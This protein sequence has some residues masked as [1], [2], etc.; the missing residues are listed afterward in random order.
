MN[1]RLQL[2]LFFIITALSLPAQILFEENFEGGSVPTDWSIQTNATDGGWKVGTPASLSTN[3]FPIAA[4]GSTRIAATNDDACNCNKS[5]EYFVTPVIDLSTVSTAVLTFDAYYLGQ[6]YQGDTEDASVDISLDGGNTWTVLMPI[7]G[8]PA[9]VNHQVNLTD[10]VGQSVTIGFRYDDNGGWL[11]GFGLDNVVVEVPPALE[12][13]LVEVTSRIFGE[14][15][16]NLDIKGELLNAG[17]NA[18]TSVE[19][20]YTVNGGTPVVETLDNLNIAAFSSYDFQTSSPW[21]PASAG[22]F[23]IEVSVT[24]V[25]GGQDGNPDDNSGSYEPEI[26]AQ[27]TVPNKIAT[28][29]ET[30]PILT[31]MTG[32]SSALNRPTDLDFFPILGKDELWV[33]NQRTESQGGSTLTISD[34]TA[35]TPTN[36]NNLTDGN[37]WHFMSLPSAIAFSSDNF[38]FANSPGVQDA[39][40]QGGTFTGPSLWSSDLAIYAQP[41]GGNG[42]HLDMLHGS[43][44]SRGIA[45]EVD[46][47]F[48]VYDDYNNDI[49]RY[50]FVEDHGPGNDDHSDAIVRRFQ[51]IGI[52][53][54][55]DIPN[56]MLVDKAT[57]WLYFVDNGNDRVIRLDINSGTSSNPLSEINEP[58]AE[59]SQIMGFNFEVIIDS[60]LDQPCGLEIFE[61]YLM[62]GDYATGDILVYDM[63]NDFAPM[64]VIPT[65][66]PGLTGIKVGPDGNIWYT[67][68]LQNTLSSVQPGDP[69]SV[70]E[71]KAKLD[72]KVSPNPT[73]G[74]VNVNLEAVQNLEATTI[75]VFNAVGQQTLQINATDNNQELDLSHMPNGV[76]WIKVEGERVSGTQRVVLNR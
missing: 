24:M 72:F 19:L 4:N 12:I 73:N 45:H 15:G 20:S 70:S 5:N 23:D 7:E 49:V 67:N 16:D 48:W 17:A 34:A 55:G 58:L 1:K 3:A 42:S 69:V 32:A 46:N 39:N 21:V 18:I 27:V 14:V 56:H 10:Y 6:T 65:L 64:G 57:G 30:T 11:Y 59:H 8:E 75:Q 61:N 52:N 33:I 76:Y 44:L 62:I 63:S 29:L 53:G 37:A 38:N 47:V 41:S 66:E 51:G 60:G 28:M 43:P 68:R 54:D 35:D 74:L 31:E 2:S 50:D 40:H 22:M 25:N 71:T 13:K 36:F 9:W 26:F